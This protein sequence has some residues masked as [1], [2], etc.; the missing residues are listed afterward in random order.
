M[1]CVNP[2]VD[3]RTAR[4]ETAYLEPLVLQDL[5]DSNLGGAFWFV[6]ELGLEHDSKRAVADDLAVGVDE[7]PHVAGLAVRG[8][9]LDDLAGIIDGCA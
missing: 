8:D 7:I 5:L 4:E 3:V 9:N 1:Q 6:E 2:C